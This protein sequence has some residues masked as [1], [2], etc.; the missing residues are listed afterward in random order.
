MRAPFKRIR[1]FNRLLFVLGVYLALGVF[2]AVWSLFA[3]KQGR[4][5]NM[6][7]YFSVQ[8]HL[9]HQGA[10]NIWQNDSA[11]YTL[12]AE[13]LY[14][15]YLGTCRFKNIEF[16]TTLTF[17]GSGRFASSRPKGLGIAVLGDSHSMGWGVE[18]Q[19]TF[20]HFL[21]MGLNRPV[22]NLAVSSYGTNRELRRLELSGLL[23]KVDTVVLQYCD[24]DLEEN[25]KVR[26]GEL[27]KYVR[28]TPWQRRWNTLSYAADSVWFTWTQPL[29]ALLA[30][31]VGEPMQDFRPHAE[32]FLWALQR[33][34]FLKEKRVVVFYANS[35]G[36][37]FYNFPIGKAEALPHV[38]YVNITTEPMH[39]Y[40]LDDHWNVSGHESVA[41]QLMKY[42]SNSPAGLN[43]SSG[44]AESLLRSTPLK[45]SRAPGQTSR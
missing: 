22:Y 25:L 20:S 8:Q 30:V 24:N 40:K 33:A 36:K 9:Y 37:R 21:Q 15:P 19:E 35:R 43:L 16:D 28:P 1:F 41:T 7:W 13:L 45:H 44:P 27:G 26:A 34:P 32:P 11:C 23:P 6:P 5:L 31:F 2:V 14:V 17:D 4:M 42:L 38:E 29:R 10:R 12:D 18:D 39:F 3:L